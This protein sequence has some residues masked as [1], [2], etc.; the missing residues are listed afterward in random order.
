MILHREGRKLVAMTG[1]RIPIT[2]CMLSMAFAPLAISGAPAAAQTAEERFAVRATVSATCVV[3]TDSTGARAEARASV[4]CTNGARWTV[5]EQVSLRPARRF[6]VTAG[7]PSGTEAR[8]R[9]ITITY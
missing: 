3:S 2:S 7:A 6:L 8:I 1:H 4:A 5:S 9:V